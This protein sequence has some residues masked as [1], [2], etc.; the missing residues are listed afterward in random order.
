MGLLCIFKSKV[1]F[2]WF[3]RPPA[4][5]LRVLCVQLFSTLAQVI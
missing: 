5:K 3:Q 1:I 2:K 4:Y